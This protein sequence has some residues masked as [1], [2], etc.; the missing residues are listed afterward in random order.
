M[1]EYGDYPS[2]SS[3]NKSGTNNTAAAKP[4]KATTRLEE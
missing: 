1:V 3:K 2:Q 4:M